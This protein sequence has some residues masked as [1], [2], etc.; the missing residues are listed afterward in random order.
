MPNIA[1]FSA[2][3]RF[4]QYNVGLKYIHSANV[5]HRDLKPSNILVNSDC[6]LAICDFGLSRGAEDEASLTD[7]VVTRYPH[8]FCSPRVLKISLCDSCNAAGIVHRKSFAT[9]KSM[10]KRWT[11][12]ARG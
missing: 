6:A 11:F 1:P 8:L 5:M 9:T 10:T 2:F 3:I 4:A 7:Y 12:G